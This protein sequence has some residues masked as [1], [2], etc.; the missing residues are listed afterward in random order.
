MAH[1]A[2]LPVSANL[3]GVARNVLVEHGQLGVWQK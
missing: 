2:G 1:W 3:A